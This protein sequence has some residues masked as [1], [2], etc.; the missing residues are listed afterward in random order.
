MLRSVRPVDAQHSHDAVTLM[1][2]LFDRYCD[3][4]VYPPPYPCVHWAT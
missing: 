4:S 1:R 2:T 3:L